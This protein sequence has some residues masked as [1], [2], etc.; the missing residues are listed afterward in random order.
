M[1]E[2]D[3]LSPLPGMTFCITPPRGLSMT[4]HVG[5]VHGFETHLI[6]L[7]DLCRGFR[8]IVVSAKVLAIME[9]FCRGWKPAKIAV[10]L[11]AGRMAVGTWRGYTVY[12]DSQLDDN[13]GYLADQLLVPLSRRGRKLG[14]FNLTEEDR[15]SSS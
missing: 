11:P 4:A 5:G 2:D 15:E 14:E 3:P 1:A 13:A 6:G 8:V 9:G 7:C 12:R 10:A